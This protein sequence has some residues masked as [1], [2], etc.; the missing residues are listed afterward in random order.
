MLVFLFADLDRWDRGV[1]DGEFSF[2]FLLLVMA[3]AR[4]DFKKPLFGNAVHKAVLPV[5]PAA[6]EIAQLA[7]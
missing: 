2:C 6:V 7:F 1:T 3:F 5:N 4:G